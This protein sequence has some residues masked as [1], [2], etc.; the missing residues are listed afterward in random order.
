MSFALLLVSLLICTVAQTLLPQIGWAGGAPV[1]LLTGLVVTY[2]LRAPAGLA[3]FAAMAAGLFQDSVSL[4]PLGYTSFCFSLCVLVIHRERELMITD[5]WFTHL[6]LGALAGFAVNLLTGTFLLASGLA[7]FSPG[8]F[9]N[10]LVGGALLA[11]LMVPVLHTVIQQLEGH[12]GLAPDVEG[13][14]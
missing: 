11:A 6:V 13:L 1:P 14:S 7:S 12:L 9:L 4:M 8:Y 10:R 2:A 3:L 5:S